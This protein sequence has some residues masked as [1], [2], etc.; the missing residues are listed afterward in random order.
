MITVFSGSAAYNSYVSLNEA[1]DY[2]TARNIAAW[3]SATPVA[4]EAALIS[5]TDYIDIN[6]QPREKAENIE[7]L[8]RACLM[9]SISALAGPLV[10]EASQQ[11]VEQ[12]K[13]LSGVG[14]TRLRYAETDGFDRWPLVTQMLRPISSSGGS[15]KGWR[16]VGVEK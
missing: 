6:Y 8:K 4:R 2:M 1:D 11:I 3:A 5:A 16:S 14:K 7:L 10:G 13:E 9:L 12:E 15:G